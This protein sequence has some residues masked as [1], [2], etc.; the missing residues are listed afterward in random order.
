MTTSGDAEVRRV[1]TIR[2]LG[3]EI[4]AELT[5]IPEAELHWQV[6]NAVLDL[7]MGVLARHSGSVLENDR[8]LPVTPLPVRGP[9]SH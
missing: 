3:G 5:K 8:D 6:K 4:H 9:D 1:R 2:E 7:V